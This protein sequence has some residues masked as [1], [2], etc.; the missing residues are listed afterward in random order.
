MVSCAIS[1]ALISE[2]NPT[3]RSRRAEENLTDFRHLLIESD[4]VDP[5]LWLAALVQLPLP[6]LSIVESGKRSIHALVRTDCHTPGQWEALVDNKWKPRLIRLGACQSSTSAVRLTRLPCCRRECENAEQKLLFLNPAPDFTPICEL[7]EFP[8]PTPSPESARLACLEGS[9][10][11]VCLTRLKIISE[12]EGLDSN[13]DSLPYSTRTE[14]GVIG[15][16][17]NDPACLCACRQKGISRDHFHEMQA[18]LWEQIVLAESNDRPFDKISLGDHLT[19]TGNGSC[20]QLCAR[21]EECALE[22][23]DPGKIGGYCETLINTKDRRD[24]IVLG[25]ILIKLAR[26][27]SPQWRAELQKIQ[28]IGNDVL[29]DS[30]PPMISAQDLCANPPPTPPQVIEGVLHQGSKLVLGGGAKSFKTWALL[31]LANCISTGLPWLGFETFESP[32]LYVNFELPAFNMESRIRAICAALNVPIPKNLTVW[33]LRGHATDAGIILPKI[34]RAI[35]KMGYSAVF[36]DP[37]Y[38]L[39]GEREENSA[40]DMTNLM[41]S[42]EQL[43]EYTRAAVLFGSHFAKGNASAK[44]SMDRISG[45]GVIARDPDSIITLTKH[46]EDKCFTVEFTLRNFPPQEPFVVRHEHPLMVAAHDLDPEKL[47]KPTRAGRPQEYSLDDVFAQ[48]EG[49]SM[50]SA[51]WEGKCKK[52]LV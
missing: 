41:N 47:K 6:I 12:A 19:T 9:P 34:T 13:K 42:I 15:V 4:E 35:K 48:L 5:G 26:T 11:S 40:R 28:E 33:N 3:G 36:L 14:R 31:H 46:E 38:K 21:L 20:E 8:A 52:N 50:S 1:R 10:R 18:Q 7:P 29:P 25:D 39:L 17:V 23:S 30:L 32:V 51:D 49:G 16:V 37:I 27:G 22:G 43:S 2:H 24:A 44:E 45:S